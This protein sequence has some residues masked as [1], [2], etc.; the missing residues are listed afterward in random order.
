MKLLPAG[1][2]A[3]PSIQLAEAG[4]VLLATIEKGGAGAANATELRGVVQ[5]GT[6]NP[7]KAWATQQPALLF[8]D[9]P[10]SILPF[11]AA[12]AAAPT[13]KTDPKTGTAPDPK[14]TPDPKKGPEAKTPPK[15]GG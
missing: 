3:G 1:R 4:I 15:K 8:K 14:K 5:W 11:P 6:N 2:A 12:P 13:L 9:D 10:Q 7:P